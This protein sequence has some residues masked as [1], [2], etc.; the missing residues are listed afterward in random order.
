[1]VIDAVGTVE[2]IRSATVR[3]QITGSLLKIAIHEGQDVTAGD[4]LFEIDSRPFAAALQSALADEQRIMV[5]RDSAQAQLA[6]YKALNVGTMVSQDQ[7]QQIEDNAR[8][9]QAQATAAEAAVAN[10]RLQL[11][12]CSIRAPIGGRT[13][14]LNVHE[15]DLIRA[16]DGG[17]L[18]TINQLSPIYVTFGIPQQELPLVNRYRAQ[19]TLSV[20]AALVSGE[21]HPARGD[22]TFVD[23]TVDSTTGTIKLKATFLNSGRGLW[24]GQFAN[25][26]LTLAAPEVLTVPASAVQ[27]NQNGNHVFVVKSDKT[28][29]FRPVVVERTFD[30]N[31]VITSGVTAGEAV[32]TDG[33]LR[34]VPGQPVQIK[35]PDF[36]TN[37]AAQSD[38]SGK[39]PVSAPDDKARR[40]GT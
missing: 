31:A 23:N 37:P 3:A 35:A 36:F 20:Q 6:R 27:S 22:L 5:Q 25:V 33:Q 34:V 12:Y 7:F 24:P 19:G 40:Q 1:M 9:L 29:E 2:P 26:T 28:A 11:E 8:A 16:N 21:D 18:V 17:A 39:N 4:L 30:D 38:M 32:V 10:A 13:G 14:N 15:G